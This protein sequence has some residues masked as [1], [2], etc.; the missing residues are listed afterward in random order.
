MAQP[1]IPDGQALLFNVDV[2][3]QVAAHPS[4]SNPFRSLS[5]EMTPSYLDKDAIIL[6]WVFN[7]LFNRNTFSSANLNIELRG[8][9]YRKQHLKAR[10]D[11]YTV[12]VEA[13]DTRHFERIAN[14]GM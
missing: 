1:R 5:R 7:T 4:L 9:N 2:G 12:I 11:S 3:A 13:V 8:P 14:H 10:P 6:F